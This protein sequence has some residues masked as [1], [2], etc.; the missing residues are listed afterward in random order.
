MFSRLKTLPASTEIDNSSWYIGISSLCLFYSLLLTKL[1]L[2]KLIKIM[3]RK[4]ESAA[5]SFDY[6][7]Y[8]HSYYI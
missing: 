7:F 6:F 4:S 2:I 1:Y 8:T 5:A 3:H